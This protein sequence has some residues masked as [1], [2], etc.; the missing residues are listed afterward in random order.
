MTAP[1]VHTRLLQPLNATRIDYMVTGGLAAIIYGE[2]RLTNDVDIV[3]RLEPEAAERLI[4]AYPAPRDAGTLR[5]KCLIDRSTESRWI[6]GRKPIE[7]RLDQRE[8]LEGTRPVDQA[9]G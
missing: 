8:V 6:D 7:L 1:D 5:L 4:A 2:P 3:L 9:A